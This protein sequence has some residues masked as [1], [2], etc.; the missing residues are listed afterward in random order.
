MGWERRDYLRKAVLD[1]I[2][3][4]YENREDH[5][6]AS[7]SR[8]WDS[9]NGQPAE[10]ASIEIK[11]WLQAHKILG[12]ACDK[13]EKIIVEDIGCE[14]TSDLTDYWEHEYFTKYIQ[15][16]SSPI[17]KK[18]FKKALKAIDVDVDVECKP[19]K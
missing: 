7:L 4:R 1:Q 6:Y 16:V 18:K 9:V 10:T 17:V 15:E 2:E 8:V 14:T 13:L 11:Q 19:S 3:N 12:S 5:V